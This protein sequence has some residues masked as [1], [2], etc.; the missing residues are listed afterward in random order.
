MERSM[1]LVSATFVLVLLL[2]ATE[3]GPIGVE[4]RTE[5][6]KAIEGKIC[7]FPSTLFK[8]LC[9]SSN[10]CK[11]TCKKEQFTRGKCSLLTRRCMCT[12]KC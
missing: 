11:H 8:G 7:E 3:M 4:A 10:N 12:K 5:S 6:S 1:C 2:A 9:F